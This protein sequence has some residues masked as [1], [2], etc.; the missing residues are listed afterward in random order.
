LRDCALL[1]A[2]L[3]SLVLLTPYQ[4]K[5]SA[6][7]ARITKRAAE[8]LTSTARCKTQKAGLDWVWTFD[9]K[10]YRRPYGSRL[11][12][13]LPPSETSAT[14]HVAEQCRNHYT[15]MALASELCT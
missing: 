7:G 6:G 10:R 11:Q 1:A 8:R 5:P 4:I 14:Q 3:P 13:D 9:K 15:R 12:H 2:R